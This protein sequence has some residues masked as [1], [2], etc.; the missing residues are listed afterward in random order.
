[1]TLS[2][3]EFKKAIDQ[4]RDEIIILVEKKLDDLG[5]TR[6]KQPKSRWLFWGRIVNVLFVG[7][8][9]IAMKVAASGLIGEPK[10]HP[11]EGTH[12]SRV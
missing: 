9:N 1:M 5:L 8:Y 6:E 2:E 3:T 7:H 10:P 11:D 12:E 4:T